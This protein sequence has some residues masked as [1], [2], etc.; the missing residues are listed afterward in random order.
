[1]NSDQVTL[2]RDS[3]ATI[4]ANADVLSTRFYAHLFEIDD[5]AARLFAGV[6]MK[7]QRTKLVHALTLV[8]ASVDDVDRLLPALAALGKRHA[9]YGIEQRHFD[10]VGD[11]LLWALS[12][13]L[14]DAFTLELRDVWA[15]AYVLIASVMRRAI[16]RHQESGDAGHAIME[17]SA[18]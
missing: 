11:A 4:G 12:D 9:G 6:D 7:A 13:V 3:W 5:D 18:T 2:I 16:E 10:S 15:R 8:V 14:G 1:M 17:R